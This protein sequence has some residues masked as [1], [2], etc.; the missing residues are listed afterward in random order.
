V[1][2]AIPLDEEIPVFV[3]HFSQWKLASECDSSYRESRSS[4]SADEKVK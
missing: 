2:N 3:V 1:A 4:T